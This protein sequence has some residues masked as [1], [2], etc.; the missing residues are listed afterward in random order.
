LRRTLRELRRR[1]E[2]KLDIFQ[3]EENCATATAQAE[4]MAARVQASQVK[5][6]IFDSHKHSCNG[7]VRMVARSFHD[8]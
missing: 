4:R 3:M 8:P 7:K 6:P 5:L 1:K 2:P